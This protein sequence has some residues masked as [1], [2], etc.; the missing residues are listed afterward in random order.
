MKKIKGILL[1]L[2]CAIMAL[3]LASCDA[4]TG[5]LG[6]GTEEPCA[7][8]HSFAAEWSYDAV[9]HWHA[10]TCEHADAKGDLAMHQYVGGVCVCGAV[11]SV[12][13]HQHMYAASWS[14]DEVSHWH[15]ATCEHTDLKRDEAEHVYANGVCICG[16][17]EPHDHTF[18]DTLSYSESKHWYAS[19]CGHNVKSGEAAHELDESYACTVCDFKHEHTYSREWESDGAKH[20]HASTCGHDV[21]AGEAEHSY[22]ADFI[23]TACGYNH[24]HTY[25]DEWEITAEGH[26]REATCGHAVKADEGAHVYDS[27]FVCTAC[28]YEH[29][30]TYLL[31]AWEMDSL[32]HWHAATCG[33]AVRVDEGAHEFVGGECYCGAIEAH[34]HTYE[35][36]WS[37]NESVHWHASTCGHDVK[38]DTAA[39]EYGSDFICDTCGYEHEHTYSEAWKSDAS[40]HWHESDCHTGFTSQKEEH[41]LDENYICTVCE[42]KH[43]HTY[44]TDWEKDADKHW[45][46]SDC[47]AGFISGE[48]AHTLD[49][50]YICVSC[51]YRHEHTYSTEWEKDADKHWHESDC[52]AGLVS[53]EADHD[54]GED[55]RCTVCGYEH[56]HTYASGWSY[57]ESGHWHASTCG[58]DVKGDFSEH[59]LGGDDACVGNCGYKYVAPHSHSYSTKWSK[60][61]NYHW[62]AATCEHSD[63]VISLGAHEYGDDDVC[64]VCEC[65]RPIVVTDINSGGWGYSDKKS[66]SSSKPRIGTRELI[67]V[68]AGT[69]IKYDPKE[70][71][72][73]LD[74]PTTIESNSST[75]ATDGSTRAGWFYTPGEYVVQ[76]DAYLGIT[77]AWPDLTTAIKPSQYNCDIVIFP[78][79]GE[80]ER[81]YDKVNVYRFG[82]E[83]N[84]WCFVYLPEGYDPNRAEP[85]P[86]VIA[87]HGNGWNMDGSLKKANWTDNTMYMSA[88]EI[89]TQKE[90]K[91]GRFIATEDSSLWYSNP[92]IEAL[93]AAG[94]IVCGAQ[95][96]GDNLYGNDDCTD[97]VV[98][99][100]NHMTATYNV[101]DACHMIGASNG[102]MTTLGAAE[103]LGDKVKSMIIQYPLASIITHYLAGGHQDNIEAAYGLD[104]SKTYTRAELEA[105]LAEYD[106][107][108]KNVVNGVKQGYYP[109]LKIYYSMT[110]TL[111]TANANALP[112]IELLQN[113]GK[114]VVGVQVDADGS[115]RQHGDSAHFD[116]DGYLEWFEAH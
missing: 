35:S 18:S 50:N 69:V 29:E 37:R 19:T 100:F 114:E 90:S 54:F 91:R 103:K 73:Y 14:K 75:A 55:L 108:Y 80:V 76:N 47:H 20:W 2:L 66:Y 68:K 56:Q 17:V 60:D 106:V 8:G 102:A 67:F 5:L 87:N 93:L 22:G 12:T 111:T 38:S 30:H 97:A 41:A 4:I 3:G 77:I 95:N 31:G 71:A 45:H 16:A 1:I 28:G 36:G 49:S 24:E 79:T 42:H 10:A 46:V 44:S 27:E 98:D 96:Y 32:S 83:G 65:I 85:Y 84:D 39:H 115:N 11:E 101:E 116:P 34:D 43:E 107:L 104:T 40:G 92:T 105:V 78:G 82:G 21:K 89:A 13:E 57:D 94:Y 113:S 109:A 61:A 48:E 58:H 99:F 74:L 112:V 86:F 88:A 62:H 51:G 33:H 9:Q 64:D 72:I 26:L 70:F 59:F 110:D 52:H 23:C 63:E 53:S 81:T 15:A 7:N 6:G 25:S